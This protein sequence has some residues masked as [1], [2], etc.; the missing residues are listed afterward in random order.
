[1]DAK[2]TNCAYN[3]M[4]PELMEEME[5]PNEMSDMFGFCSLFWELFN[6]FYI[7]LSFK[8]KKKFTYH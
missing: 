8:I 6:G 5:L 3:W 1:M 2:R 4:A 7:F